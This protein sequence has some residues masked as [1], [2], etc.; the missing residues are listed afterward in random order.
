[1]LPSLSDRV[2]I[3]LAPDR[4]AGVRVRRGFEQKIVAK[5][6]VSC[7][8]GASRHAWEGAVNV[9]PELLN[10]IGSE[11]AAA[12]LI[13]SNSFVRYAVVPWSENLSTPKDEMAF[14]RHCLSAIYGD[15]VNDW[16]LRLS[17]GGVGE[18]RIASAVDRSLLQSVRGAVAK[19]RLRVRS[20]QPFLMAAFNRWQR[21]LDSDN[22]LFLVVESGQYACAAIR[23]AQ[24]HALHSGT[25]NG[26]LA[27]ELPHV[28]N[29]E[30]LWAD[31]PDR[32]AAFLYAPEHPNFSLPPGQNWSVRTLSLPARP[33]FSPI[34]DAQY[35]MT[36]S[37][38]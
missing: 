5:Q 27:A 24:W 26:D 9:L 18:P 36:M 34:S 12:T 7:V 21:D 17:P 10:E 20:I 16:E 38:A 35:A 15:A 11:S 33:G 3:A 6:L 22:C 25:V 31:M 1:M 30:S 28:L 19:S 13:L 29:R 4:V 32:P 14:A 23:N 37:A 8:P 2:A